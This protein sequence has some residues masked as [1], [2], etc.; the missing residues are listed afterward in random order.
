MAFTQNTH[1]LEG[2]VKDRNNLPLGNVNIKI[3]NSSKGTYSNKSG[4]YRINNIA[5]K[6]ITI[7]YSKIGYSSVEKTISLT[8]KLTRLNVSLNEKT[9][10]LDEVIVNA[11]EFKNKKVY[12]SNRLNTKAIDM[13]TTS[14]A[15]SK[16]LFNKQQALTLGDVMTNVSGVFQFNKGYGGV[17]ETFGA[18]GVSLRYLGFMFRDGIRFSTNQ[19]LGTAD[20]QAFEKVE[21]LK[22]GAAI[23]FG[24]VSPGATI[25]YVTK[26]PQFDTTGGTLSVRYGSYGHI[27][28]TVDLN[29]KASDKTA[30]RFISTMDVA[31]SFRETVK[32]RRSYNYGAFR[33]EP[34]QKTTID[35][36]VDHLFDKR[37]FDFGLPIFDNL[38]ITGTRAGIDRQGN[39][40]QVPVYLNET[41]IQNLYSGIT[42]SVRS[43][44]L[45]SAFNNRDSNQLNANAKINTELNDQWNLMVAVGGSFS[46][47]DFVR[48]GS[49]FN[50]RYFLEPDGDIR[51]VRTLE[52]Q[53]WDESGY[54]AQA[55]LTGKFNIAGMKNNMSFSIDYDNR[56]QESVNYNPIR[57]FDQVFLTKRV[58]EREL[59]EQE[60]A[61][62]GEGRFK[63]YGASF[64]NLLNI[65]D[66]LNVLAS[67]RLDVI[68][69]GTINKYLIDYRGNTAGSVSDRSFD[70]VA[71]TPSAGI[72]YKFTEDN[73]V[74]ASYTN[75]FVPNSR[76][77]LGED[78]QILDSYYNT[79]FEIG[80]KN[81]FLDNKITTNATF[82]IMNS[83]NYISSPNVPER[84]VVGPGTRY[85]GVELD[86]STSPIEGLTF[87]TNYSYI[88]AE[89]NKGGFFLAG[90]RPQQ[91]PE[92]QIGFWSNYQF[93]KGALKDLSINLGG[94]Y[95]SERL[96]NDFYR[97]ITPY[98]QEAYTLLNAGVAYK[99]NNFNIAARVTNLLDEFVFFS[100][101]YGSV[102]P[103]EPRQFSVTTS[104]VF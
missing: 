46:N 34:S 4:Y 70:D 47:Y 12:A 99:V 67:V 19:Y 77:R 79:Q 7:K 73:A 16:E 65:T 104:Y 62:L 48:T 32:S 45:G 20:L 30:F 14:D 43:R 28:P 60:R 57:G 40:T 102:N 95:T 72:T 63:G 68:E 1:Y 17:S 51:I 103:I 29:V 101:R 8:N 59:I 83:D 11:E 93:T 71:F 84:Y 44:F 15:V 55:N 42:K 81:S 94:Q 97:G 52:K 27:K 88:D 18:R 56:S 37:P 80:T 85:R 25:N 9:N 66:K 87:N 90:T 54:G 86:L 21:V 3:D 61:Y 26:K 10:E 53:E 69:G 36:N 82:Y 58:E 74:F 100:Y 22:G 38:V 23:N 96:G 76:F 6:L 24:Y 13:P 98:V 75:T 33:Y 35:V 41:K 92:H 91:T 89:Y 31:E 64:Q 39:L 2:Y 5:G 50:N 78:D 49:G